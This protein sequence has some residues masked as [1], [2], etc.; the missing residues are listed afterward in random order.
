DEPTTGL[1]PAG[2]RTVWELVRGL[3]DSGTSLLLTTQ[4]LEEAEE[5]AD[6]IVVI[7]KGSAIA[8][9]SP[10]SL[11]EQVGGARLEVHITP[12]AD[13]E[14]AVDAVKQ[15]SAGR[16]EIAAHTDVMIMPVDKETRL[17]ARVIRALDDQGIDVA[18]VRMR[19]PT[20]DDVFLTLT[21]NRSTQP[22]NA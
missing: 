4:Y 18:D 10:D 15:C 21:G 20:L 2:R 11:K 14:V 6:D 17:L 13:P 5:L 16:A 1:D 12:G 22:Q 9:G 8:Q 3:V 7:D 19:E